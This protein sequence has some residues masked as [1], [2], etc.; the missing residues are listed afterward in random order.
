MK[1]VSNPP[2]RIAPFSVYL[3]GVTDNQGQPCTVQL[4]N[5]VVSNAIIKFTVDTIVQAYLDYKA[6]KIKKKE[7]E[8]IKSEQKKKLP[9][10]TFHA[11][12]Q[13][14]RKKESIIALSGLAMHD[15]DHLDNPREIYEKSIKPLI[16]ELNILLVHIT[17]GGGLR[18]VTILPPHTTLEEAQ[19]Q[20]AERLGLEAD[21]HVKDVARCSFAVPADYILYIN[22]DELFKLR[23]CDDTP[24]SAPADNADNA[25][26]ADTPMAATATAPAPAFKG[27]PFSRIIE[28]WWKAT[29]GEPTEGERNTRLFDLARNLALLTDKNE[30]RLLALLPDYGL[31]EAEMKSIVHSACKSD[32]YMLSATMRRILARFLPKAKSEEQ[33]CCP[34]LPKKLPRLLKLLTDPQ[35]DIYKPAVAISV[36]PALA[37]YVSSEVKVT[38]INGLDCP[39]IVMTLLIA[40]TGTGKSC[41][42]APIDHITALLREQDKANRALL[43]KCKDENNAKGANKDKAL[44]PKV[45]IRCVSHDMTN[46]ALVELLDNAQGWPL[47]MRLD[48][49][50]LL[51]VLGKQKF[52]IMKLSFDRDEYGQ[53]RVGDKSV[54]KKVL[55][56]LLMSLA[57]TPKGAQQFFEKELNTG[58]LSRIIIC[59][60]PP[61]EIGAPL[62]VFGRYDDKFDANLRPYLDNLQ[63]ARGQ[64]RCKQVE[65]IA[66]ELQRELADNAVAMQ[67]KVYDN[68][69]HRALVNGFRIGTLLYLANNCKWEKAIGDFMRWAVHYTLCCK[70]FYFGEAI[71]NDMETPVAHFRNKGVRNALWDLPN[72]FTLD[73]LRKQRTREGKENDDRHCKSII[74]K[75][76][77]RGFIREQRA[78]ADNADNKDNGIR[79][80]KLQYKN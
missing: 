6:G 75:W 10:F 79:Y 39:L 80:V 45:A 78:G 74:S 46:A 18:L 59:S 2:Q 33:L 57:T 9:V 61:A 1:T 15:Y 41:I 23:D 67:D 13:G 34:P 52:E 60:L 11:L 4:F 35:P 73:D 64:V 37:A 72:I 7:Y 20:V 32:Y 65:N 29:G 19:R 27:V 55:V 14:A 28:E 5:S 54:S 58:P 22:R 69:A 66:R 24:Q 43:Q 70:M 8:K 30:A 44:K 50:S 25:D 3:K 62:P 56:S 38:Y 12:F 47:Y 76:M 63:K 36:L 16:D 71:R 17:P 77:G 48:E 42:N 51:D 53:E 26:N 31:P 40:P 49:L 21:P 68:L